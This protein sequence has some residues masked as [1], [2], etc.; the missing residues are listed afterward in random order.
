MD[1]SAA[2]A[3]LRFER[4][5]LEMDDLAARR[6]DEAERCVEQRAGPTTINLRVIILP[7][8]LRAAG[9]RS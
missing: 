5:G 9:C 4:E 1:C 2:T 8:A 7:A 3:M 6:S